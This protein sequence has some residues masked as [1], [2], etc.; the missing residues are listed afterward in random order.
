MS[1]AW[2]PSSPVVAL[3]GS[4]LHVS[5]VVRTHIAPGIGAMMTQALAE[6]GASKIYIVGRRMEKLQE[7]ASKYPTY[8]LPVS[9][10]SG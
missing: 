4:R 5:L 6:N 7:M 1:M 3:V 9:L 8:V 2:L 10:L